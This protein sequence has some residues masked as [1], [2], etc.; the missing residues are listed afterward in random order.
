QP[1]SPDRPAL[2][3]RPSS[4]PRQ[5]G[6]VAAGGTSADEPATA[7]S[8]AGPA[9]EPWP[10]PDLFSPAPWDDRRSAPPP[11]PTRP[12]SGAG[13]APP[14]ASGLHAPAPPAGPASG[15]QPVGP[16]RQP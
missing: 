2:P 1:A 14:W 13:S 15:P 11:P 10:S 5:P 8:A 6:Q 7:G 9:G 16:P 3:R 4:F 12:G